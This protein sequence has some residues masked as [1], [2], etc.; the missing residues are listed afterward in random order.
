MRT[1]SPVLVNAVATNRAHPTTFY[2]PDTSRVGVGSVVK[3]SDTSERFWVRVVE[4][5]GDYLVGVIEN[6]LLTGN[7]CWHD[8]IQFHVDNILNIW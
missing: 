6:V 4:R 3:V 7:L 8:R 5:D 2:V 1:L